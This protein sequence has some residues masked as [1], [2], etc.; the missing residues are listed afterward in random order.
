MA[1]HAVSSSSG[2]S[3]DP[4][5][6]R[7]ETNIGAVNETY[8]V[9]TVAT[10]MSVRQS[11]VLPPFSCTSTVSWFLRAEIHFRSVNLTDEE[12]KADAVMKAMTDETFERIS[13]WVDA[14]PGRVKY[15][16]LK[17]KMTATFSLSVPVRAARIIDLA[18]QPLGDIGPLQAWDE[19]RGLVMLPDVDA[20]GKRKEISLTKEVFL[21]RLPQTV[22][23]QIT[24]AITLSMDDLAAKAQE[25]FDAEKASRYAAT[26]SLNAVDLE[27]E[28]Q[29]VDTNAIIR[30]NQR[31]FQPHSG[32]S[33]RAYREKTSNPA[34]CFYH[35]T[36]GER[37]RKCRP[38]CKYPK[39]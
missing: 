29:S 10:L 25:L 27:E 14:H 22:R 15:Q 24:D 6:A 33:S 18:S 11:I 39:N 8:V 37:A 21:R 2:L 20:D 4:N 26:L 12:A 5:V 16:D 28:E 1:D 23:A 3:E 31:R 38:P 30:Q 17:K 7:N 34:W 32:K 9:D 19:L 35:N 36:F 13:S